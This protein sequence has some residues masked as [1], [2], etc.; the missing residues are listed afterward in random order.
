MTK[1]PES[2]A[3]KDPVQLLNDFLQ[4]ENLV[5]VP[6]QPR[7]EFTSGGGAIFTPTFTVAFRS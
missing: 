7:V 6:G 1:T 3:Q 4:K 5:L 2:P